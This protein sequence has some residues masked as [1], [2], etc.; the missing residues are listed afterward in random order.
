MKPTKEVK[1]YGQPDEAVAPV[2]ESGHTFASVTDKISSIVL[3]QKTP[4][5]WWIGFALSFLLFMVLVVSITKLVFV[6]IGIW[7][8]NE[9]VGWAFDIISFVWWIGIGHAGTLIS[10]I[11]LLLRQSWRTS[12]NRF[13]ALLKR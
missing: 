10:A 5:G 12:I 11:L 7:G 2:I 3:M 9:P 13:V 8:E 6:G 4:L 1:E